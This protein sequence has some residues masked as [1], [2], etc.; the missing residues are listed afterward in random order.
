[1]KDRV[2]SL[3]A[4]RF[5]TLAYG[6]AADTVDEYLRLAETTA[7]SCLHNFTD[8]IIEL[9]GKEYLRRPTP[10]DLQRLLDIGEQRGFSR[11][12]G[13]IDCMHWEWKNCPSAWKGQYTRTLNDINVLERSPVFD[14]IIEG[15]APRVRYMVNG[16]MYKSA[17]YLTDV[18]EATRKDVERA[19][20]V[21]QARF[22]IVKNPV[23]TLDKAKISKIMR[24]CIILHNMI[25]ENVRDGYGTQFDISDFEEGDVTRSSRV[26]AN[27]PTNLNNIFPIR[28]DVRD[29]RIHEHL[30]TDLIEHIWNKFG[31]EY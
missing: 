17:Y 19:F 14:D 28:N 27:M 9:F 21:L 8:G 3:L 24:A 11:M 22:A 5:A 2:V 30:K 23:K 16:H 25:V 13:S 10:E 1:M 20:G 15:R 6:S 29:T 4:S 12:I 7:L 18:Q 31:D 26:E